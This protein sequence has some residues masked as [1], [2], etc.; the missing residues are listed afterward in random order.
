MAP[1]PVVTTRIP[2]RDDQRLRALAQER[3]LSIA[4]TAAALLSAGLAEPGEECRPPQDGPLVSAVRTLLAD[5]PGPR[6]VV[7]RELGVSL[8]RTI[9]R[10]EPG[11]LNAMTALRHVLGAYQDAED[12]LTDLRGASTTLRSLAASG[13]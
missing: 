1:N 13:R 2:P 4:A 12:V 11:H 3:G 6:G 7:D 5:A 8:A 9:E 10:R